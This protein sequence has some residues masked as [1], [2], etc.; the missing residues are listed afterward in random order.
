MLASRVRLA[1]NLRTHSYPGTIAASE[2]GEVREQII[3]A[4]RRLPPGSDFAII[5][6]D[7]L[8]PLGRRILFERGLVPQGFSLE[9]HRAIVQGEG[10]DLS[11]AIGDEDHLRIAAVGAGACLEAVHARIDR[12]DDEL[13]AILPYAV[14]PEW[15]YLN[16]AVTNLGTGL[17][18]SVMLHLPGLAMNGLLARAVKATAQMGVSIRGFFGEGQDSLGDLYLVANEVTIGQSEREIVASL[19]RVGAQLAVWEQRSREELAAKRRMDIE[20]RVFRALGL[21]THCRYLSMRE[22]VDALGSLR[23]GVGLEMIDRPDLPTLT[24]LLYLVQKAH[25]Q[26]ILQSRQDASDGRLIDYTRAQVVREKLGG[27]R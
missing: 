19:G 10:G 9:K 1:R 5:Y 20:D 2:E 17:R 6:L 8:T 13:A 12:V 3:D 25:V 27:G 14:S 18:A 15:G 7:E 4:F 26:Q 21:L 22:A 16:T 24:S 11:A 23:L